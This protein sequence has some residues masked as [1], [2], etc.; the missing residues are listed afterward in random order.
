M[1]L[2]GRGRGAIALQLLDA[3]AAPFAVKE[4]RSQIWAWCDRSFILQSDCLCTFV[5]ECDYCSL[6]CERSAIVVETERGDCVIE[7]RGDR[8]EEIRMRSFLSKNT[9]ASEG[10][11]RAIAGTVVDYSDR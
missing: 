4:R 8:V 7:G 10:K 2:N 3:I 11:Y 9:I 5:I 1:L 6:F